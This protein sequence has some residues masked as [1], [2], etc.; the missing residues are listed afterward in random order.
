MDKRT[1]DKANIDNLTALW[2]AM[3]ASAISGAPGMHA[4]T[5]WPDRHWFDWECEPAAVADEL[6]ARLPPRAM[7]PVWAA[8]DRESALQRALERN[9]FDT[10]L[11]QLAMYLPLGG[12]TGGPGNELHIETVTSPAQVESWTESCGLAF[13]YRIDVA[14]IERLAGHPAARLLLARKGNVPLGTA[15]LF[16]T[17]PVIGVHQVGV[18]PEQRGQGIA[19][20]LMRDILVACREW[21]GEFVTL[22]ASAAGEGLYRKLGFSP[23]FRIASYRR[24]GFP[25]GGD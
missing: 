20:A 22:Q 9:S 8:G 18:L 13:G 3:G 7:V 6:P 15:L 5:G 19:G 14:A 16:K 24:P 1:L 11:E 12:W 23:Q 10:C 17:G 21:R 4:C 2:R 25:G